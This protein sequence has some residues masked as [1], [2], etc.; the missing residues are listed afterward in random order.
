MFTFITINSTTNASYFFRSRATTHQT[1]SAIPGV[2]L[3]FQENKIPNQLRHF[4]VHKYYKTDYF[5][6]LSVPSHRHI[7]L[8]LTPGTNT[9]ISL[10]MIFFSIQ[11]RDWR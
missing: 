8:T 4:Y 1:E 11:Y 5:F 10:L 3:H 7:L 2:G 9:N 6:F